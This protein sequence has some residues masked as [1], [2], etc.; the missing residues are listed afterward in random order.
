VARQL[1]SR[2]GLVGYFSDALLG[3]AVSRP[4][5]RARLAQLA[6]DGAAI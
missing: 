5:L 2:E 1:H 6:R 4:A 3:A